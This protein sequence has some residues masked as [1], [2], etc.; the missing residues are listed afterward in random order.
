MCQLF[1]VR[2]HNLEIALRRGVFQAQTRPGKGL[3][4][5][6]RGAR[7]GQT[8]V[9]SGLSVMVDRQ[10]QS[11]GLG[12]DPTW[13]TDWKWGGVNENRFYI[14]G[15]LWACF[16]NYL[17]TAWGFSLSLRSLTTERSE[18]WFPGQVNKDGQGNQSFIESHGSRTWAVPGGLSCSRVWS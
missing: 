13:W 11:D 8:G 15:P 1:Q 3:I 2:K 10:S 14:T 16:T 4:K 6:S 12:G 7:Q 17:H 18:P 5:A 9:I